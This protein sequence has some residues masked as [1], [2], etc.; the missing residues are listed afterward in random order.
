MVGQPEGLIYQLEEVVRQ[1]GDLAMDMRPELT[2]K[3]KPDGSLVTQADLAVEE[4]LREN[5]TGLAPGSLFLGEESEVPELRPG[6]PVWIVD[7]IDGTD[8]YRLGLA[9]FGVSVALLRDGIFSLAAFYNPFMKEMYLALA[10]GGATL[11]GQSIKVAEKRKLACNDFVLGPSNFHRCYEFRM[12][13]KMR[14][15]GSAA[16]HLAMVADGRSCCAFLQPYIWDVAAGV[17]LIREGG[18]TV[19]FLDGSVFNEDEHLNG[20]IFDQPILASH[21]SVWKQLAANISWR[22]GNCAE[23]S[24]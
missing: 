5:L 17:L 11:N 9:Y 6:Q 21:P 20:N 22:E 4:F 24:P 2:V 7:P 19:R 1:A 16:Q 8:A 23:P 10:G 15:L 12:P 14:S 13:M 18:G 3:T